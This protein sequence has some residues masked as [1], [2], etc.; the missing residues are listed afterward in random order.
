MQTQFKKFALPI[1]IGVVLL[2]ITI[3]GLVSTSFV[4]CTKATTCSSGEC[5]GTDGKCYGPCSVGYCTTSASGNCS[6]PSAGGVYCCTGSS[7]GG[8]GGSTAYCTSGNTY[9]YSS[10][11]CCPN[12]T[13]YYYPGTHG[14]S[15]AGC[16]AQCPYIGDCGT[17][18]QKY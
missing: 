5:L 9:N 1:G 8:G 12:G 3:M 10:Q 2:A 6:S 7:G 16:Y 4:G 17:M 14:I 13:P 15:A 18:W 11:M